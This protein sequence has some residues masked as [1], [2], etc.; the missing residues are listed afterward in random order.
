MQNYT[1]NDLVSIMAKLRGPDGCPWDR[2]QTSESILRYTIEEVYEFADAVH[3]RCAE[4]MKEELGDI[5][6]QVVFHAQMARDQGNFS[7]NDVIQILCEKLIR[8]HP[9]IFA[10]GKADS[11]E[12]V[13]EVWEQI[14]VNEKG[15]ENE[16][17]L[18]N[19]PRGLPP[20]LKAEKIQKKVMKVGFEWPDFSGPLHKIK[21]EL[22]ELANEIEIW[23]SRKKS[24]NSRMAQ[25]FGDLLFSMVNLARHLEIDP[26]AAL[27]MANLKFKD[28]FSRLEELMKKDGKVLKDEPLEEME[29]YWQ[30]AKK[31]DE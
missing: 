9:H 12:R 23:R 29:R 16:P 11:A 1:F 30:K 7:I 28:R 27:E 21:E 2:K 20:L 31:D 4:S 15:M 25:E 13:I 14:K 24:K 3:V 17:L 26:A 5:L 18:S 6:L 22:E 19:I 10:N 8:R